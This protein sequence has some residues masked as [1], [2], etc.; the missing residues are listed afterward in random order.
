MNNPMIEQRVTGAS[1]IWATPLPSVLSRR[2]TCPWSTA[3][4]WTNGRE[5][6]LKI[7]DDD[8]RLGACTWVQRRMWQAGFP[9]P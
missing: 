4:G 6:V 5:V 2:E 3:F 1:N 8:A 7:R 9:C